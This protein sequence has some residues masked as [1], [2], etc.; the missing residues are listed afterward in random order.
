M[1]IMHLL[2]SSHFS[3][4][5]NVVCQIINLFKN[6]NNIEM[7]YCS[8]DG[9]IRDELLARNIKF[10]PIKSFT[11]K[12]IKRVIRE[13]KPDIIHAHDMNAS[14]IASKCCKK[15]K[16]ISHIHNNN[17]NSRGL[18]LKSLGYLYATRKIKHIFWVSQSSFEGYAFHNL[19]RKKSEV[20]YNVV[21]IKALESKMLQDNNNYSY[22]I[23]YLGRLTTPKNPI[24]LMNVFKMII[25]KKSDIKI[26][27][28]GN[29]DLE[30]ET[31]EEAK[32]LGIV[33]KIDFLGFK[34]NPYKILHDSKL[35]IM[36]SSWE[37][38]PMCVLE[39]LSLG[40]PIVSTPVDGI[41]AIVENNGVG[42]LSDDNEELVNKCILLST[43]GDLRDQMSKKCIALA[44]ELMN[45]ENYKSAIQKEYF[46]TKEDK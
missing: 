21:D 16:L 46:V 22:D 26:A 9:Q 14:Y 4:A 36:T 1:K 15:I 30:T 32:K 20:L 8:Y 45:L 29:G 33:D 7:F 6:D 35:M 37:G 10:V 43:V 44:N 2:K 5:E 23:V 12:E 27:V 17:I 42:F 19:L 39:S 25:D 41:K 3:G 31:K 18:S 40:V 13:Q 34:S 11:T 28:V 38:T 24:R